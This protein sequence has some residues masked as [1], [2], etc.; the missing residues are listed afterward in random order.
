MRHYEAIYI[1]KPGIEEEKRNELIEKIKGIFT[2]NGCEITKVDEWGM[3]KLA[4]AIQD[5]TEG[6]YVYLEFDANTDAP[7]EISRSLKLLDSILRYIIVKKG[8]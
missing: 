3:R 2:S 1:I 8:E 4:Y 5:L 6:Y 7:K